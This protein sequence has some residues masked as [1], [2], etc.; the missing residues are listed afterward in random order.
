MYDRLLEC[1]FL[2]I[3]SLLLS[4]QPLHRIVDVSLT[5]VP[6]LS[7]Q[8]VFL[9]FKSIP[10]PALLPLSDTSTSYAFCAKVS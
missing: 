6:C 5:L 1:V 10:R 2:T 3:G 4:W 7:T 9:W 8:L